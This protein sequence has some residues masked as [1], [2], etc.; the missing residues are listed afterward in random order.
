[1]RIF[2]IILSLLI[3]CSVNGQSDNWDGKIKVSNESSI[4]T[5]NTEFSPMFWNDYIVFLSTGKKNKTSNDAQD[6]DLFF[7]APSHDNRLERSALFSRTL[8][9]NQHEGPGTFKSNGNYFLYSK[10][11]YDGALLNGDDTAM[12]QI[13]QSNY[14]NGEWEVPVKSEF[15]KDQFPSCH[16]AL[17]DDFNLLVFASDR[18]EGYGKMDLYYCTRT[19][20][21]W[22]QAKNLGPLINSERNDW[23]PFIYKNQ[24]LFYSQD[25]PE[26]GLDVYKSTIIEGEFSKPIR[27]PY[28]LNSDYD[29]FG[30]IVN[31]N[32][33][34]GYLSSNRPESKGSDDIYSFT[35]S[36]SIFAYG[37]DNYNQLRLKV[38]SEKNKDPISKAKIRIKSLDEKKFKSFDQTIFNFSDDSQYDSL[39]TDSQGK[40]TFRL[41]EGFTLVE[42]SVPNKEVWTKVFLNDSE[43]NEIDVFLI[44]KVKKQQEAVEPVTEIIKDIPIAVGSVIIFD[45]IYYDYN[46][47]EIKKGAATELDE[48]VKIMRENPHLKIELRAHTDSRGNNKYNQ[49][50]S[51]KRALSVK[52]YLTQK[53]V[54]PQN[55]FAVGFGETQL[56]NHCK[57]GVKCSEA[58]HIY[59]RRTEVLILEK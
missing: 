25:H 41:Y 4:N 37:D 32:G 26:L 31:N 8:N 30:L 23:F 15:N 35:S 19:D 39:F 5:E 9:S 10:V 33:K 42:I 13:F 6:F 27:L 58:E 51:E 54:I 43:Y 47:Y 12:L 40:C 55:I 38:Q 45:N 16:P 34:Y 14:I 29:D 57:D 22:S 49:N 2:I 59:N 20:S 28:P 44:D 7:T 48:L 18:P 50:L 1:M 11:D 21:I 24:Y 46:S 56:R 36:Q 3:E 17:N 53:G 52:N